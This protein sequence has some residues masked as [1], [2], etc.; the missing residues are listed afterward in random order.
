V[1]HFIWS[2]CDAALPYLVA[3]VPYLVSQATGMDLLPQ[4][5]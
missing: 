4:T 3:A 2:M 1:R 5:K